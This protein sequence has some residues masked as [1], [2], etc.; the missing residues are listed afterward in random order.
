MKETDFLKCVEWDHI[1]TFVIDGKNTLAC[2][3]FPQDSFEK[4]DSVF[5][6]APPRPP[7]SQELSSPANMD[8]KAV[9]P[10]VFCCPETPPS[11]PIPHTP[12]PPPHPAYTH[13]WTVFLTSTY[14]GCFHST[15]ISFLAR[16]VLVQSQTGV[17]PDS[18]P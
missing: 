10:M 14:R 11:L 13:S 6:E 9:Q 16:E 12:L 1:Q 18:G 7:A 2:I 8:F 3:I 5:S 4:Q 17:W 15:F